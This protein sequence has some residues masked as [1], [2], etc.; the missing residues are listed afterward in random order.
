MIKWMKNHGLRLYD[1]GGCS[2]EK[3]PETYYF[4]KSICG[5]NHTV[6]QRIGIMDL[7]EN[8]LSKIAFNTGMHIQ[9]HSS[10][11][12]KIIKKLKNSN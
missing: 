8:P 11:L 10:L 6:Y 12:K 2:P 7:C 4:K 5:K 3:V 9:K 1:L